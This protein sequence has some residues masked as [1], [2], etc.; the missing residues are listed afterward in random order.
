MNDHFLL[1]IQFIGVDLDLILHIV[2]DEFVT[3]ALLGN[4]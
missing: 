3:L 1:T 4:G 2:S